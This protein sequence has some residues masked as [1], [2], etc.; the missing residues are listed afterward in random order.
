MSEKLNLENY[1]SNEKT[2]PWIKLSLTS[3]N[4]EQLL[5]ILILGIGIH[6][7]MNIN[8]KKAFIITS[9]TYGLGILLWFVFAMVMEMNF[10]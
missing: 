8:Y 6:K 3:I 4:L 2:V 7:L 1:I 9:K 10:N 5:I